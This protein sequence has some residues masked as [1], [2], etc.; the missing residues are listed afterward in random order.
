M[1]E[2][3]EHSEAY[4]QQAGEAARADGLD[5]LLT[6]GTHSRVATHAFG[7]QGQHFET[8]EA[9]LHALLPLLDERTT[10]LVKGSRSSAME[11]IVNQL[12]A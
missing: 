8:Q 4:H 1:G 7:A 3:G 6:C 2:L 5:K 12:V 10:V 11:N 9:L